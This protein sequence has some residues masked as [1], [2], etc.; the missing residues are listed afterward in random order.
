MKNRRIEGLLFVVATAYRA[1]LIDGNYN[2][3]IYIASS[4]T[5][6]QMNIV[7]DHIYEQD[8]AK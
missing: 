2:I 7:G 1:L 3:V 4:S 6:K 8:V 5:G